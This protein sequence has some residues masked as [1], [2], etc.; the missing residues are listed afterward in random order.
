MTL[1]GDHRCGLL[2]KRVYEYNRQQVMGRSTL[3]P[4]LCQCFSTSRHNS[5]RS[6]HSPLL[7][8]A[9][10]LG[11]TS[12][13][14]WASQYY[15]STPAAS[16]RQESSTYSLILLILSN[17]SSIFCFASNFIW[18]YFNQI[19]LQFWYWVCT[20]C[21]SMKPPFAFQLR[22]FASFLQYCT[23]EQRVAAF[24]TIWHYSGGLARCMGAVGPCFVRLTFPLNDNHHQWKIDHH[25]SNVEIINKAYIQKLLEKNAP[26]HSRSWA[27]DFSHFLLRVHSK[28]LPAAADDYHR[29]GNRSRRQTGRACQN[30]AKCF[31]DLYLRPCAL[32]EN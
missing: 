8:Y 29:V 7:H 16:P 30:G 2:I 6:I 24:S 32:C 25:S 20:Q 19:V 18:S 26:H 21:F 1:P 22:V 17:L 31:N 4:L 27:R 23:Y 11:S 9:K 13:K 28:F 12:L 14:W 15:F 10:L 5:R 3:L